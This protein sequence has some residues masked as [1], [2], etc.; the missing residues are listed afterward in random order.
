MH[1]SRRCKHLSEL[2]AI[3]MAAVPLLLAAST[4]TLVTFHFQSAADSSDLLPFASLYSDFDG[5]LQPDSAEL[6]AKR[7]IRLTFS[8]SP[9][10]RLRFES[11]ALDRGRLLA[12]DID[13]DNDADLVWVSLTQPEAIL[14]WTG[15]GKGHFEAATDA[16]RY[17]AGI[18]RLL[19]LDAETGTCLPGSS[20]DTDALAAPADWPVPEPG[21]RAVIELLTASIGSTA[22]NRPIHPFASSSLSTR[23]PPAL[24]C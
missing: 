5:D 20:A 22:E 9:A 13:H 24:S 11:S 15:D 16:R 12:G 3:L 2:L 7:E 21:A 17:D 18:G 4:G 8:N 6:D 14:V 10:I 19:G 23:A 1:A